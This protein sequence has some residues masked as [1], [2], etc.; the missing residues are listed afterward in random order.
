VMLQL[1][2]RSHACID[3]HSPEGY[4]FP[5]ISVRPSIF[6]AGNSRGDSTPLVMRHADHHE[7]G[8]TPGIS[9][10]AD[11]Y[12]FQAHPWESGGTATSKMDEG[13]RA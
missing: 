12:Q 6:L 7:T 11:A 13:C 5:R 4:K 9:M 8:R 1:C 10:R 3:H 2:T